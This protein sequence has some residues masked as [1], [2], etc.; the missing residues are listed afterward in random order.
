MLSQSFSLPDIA[1]LMLLMARYLFG[2]IHVLETAL[3]R[4]AR[5]LL[6]TLLTFSNQST[7]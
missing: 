6:G 4:L 5:F 2:L 1:L 7:S 3:A